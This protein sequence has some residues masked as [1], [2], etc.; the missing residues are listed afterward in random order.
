[1]LRRY[2]L[3][4]V[5]MGLALTGCQSMPDVDTSV[6]NVPVSTQK[7]NASLRQVI[8]TIA[9][10]DERQGIIRP[11]TEAL[12]PMWRSSV[13]S[14]L[15]QAQ[16]LTPGAPN[17]IDIRV[18]VIRLDNEQNGDLSITTTSIASYEVI[19]VSSGQVT[20]VRGISTSSTVSYQ[21]AAVQGT[22]ERISLNRSI[23]A[24]I[25]QFVQLLGNGQV[26]YQQVPANQFRI[27]Q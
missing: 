3:G 13:M 22:R 2:F 24:N 5:F 17:Q 20:W 10:A 9:P 1:M 8:V 15:T 23:Q 26:E 19:D 11:E 7:V 16:T 21:E 4:A 12:L 6:T 14:S 18:K 25:A 27:Q